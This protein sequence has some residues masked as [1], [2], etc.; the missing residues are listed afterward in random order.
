MSLQDTM[1][2]NF[3]SYYQCGDKKF[4]NIFQAFE[5]QKQ[6]GH[7]PKFIVDQDLI[8]NIS[9]RKKPKDISPQAIRKLL[10]DRL[11]DLRK[12]YRKLK[13]AYSGGTDSYTILKLCVD[14]DIYV[15]ETITIMSSLYGNVRVDLEYLAGLKLAKEYEGTGIGKCTV[16]RPSSDDLLHVNDPDWFL[17]DKYV[18]GPYLPFRP[19]WLSQIIKEEVKDGGTVVLTGVEKPRLVID[20]GQPNWFLDD[21]ANELMG[22]ENT[23][24]MFIDKEN[25][26]L[27]VSLAYASLPFL[28]N[29]QEGQ[30]F[31]YHTC[32]RETKLKMLAAYGFEK[33]PYNFIN[34]N[35]LGKDKFYFNTKTR[36]FFKELEKNGHA[37]Y[38]EKMFATHKRI[39]DLYKDLPHAIEFAG[40]LSKP[41]GRMSQKIPILQHKFG[42]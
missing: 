13:L 20:A 12:K 28:K 21:S 15:D 36:Y 37:D 34:D 38:T 19:Y 9:G 35:K 42:S 30:H 41:I 39:K 11:K 22:V 7:F 23:V 26:D 27:V 32:D 6:T 2:Y 14:N 33:T 29:Q 1:S 31:G 40:N 16:I 25:P 17:D 3:K 4:Y 10:V 24:P 5:H 18:R 8:D